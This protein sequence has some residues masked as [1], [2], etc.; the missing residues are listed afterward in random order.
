MK[1]YVLI[2]VALILSAFFLTFQN[3]HLMVPAALL[4][5]FVADRRAMRIF[6]RGKFLLFLAILAFGI[7]LFIGNRA[8]LFFGI[9]YSHDVFRMSLVMVSRSVVIL[10]SIKMFTNHISVEQMA[11]ALQRIRLNRFSEV[12]SISMRALPE[13]RIIAASTYREYR[14]TPKQKNLFSESFDWLVKLVV[15]LLTYADRF[16]AED[17]IKGE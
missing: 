11:A 8:D 14:R 15:R 16:S 6:L 17:S 12:F 7:P 1:R 4:A 10:L 5:V 3:L 9:P 2:S 13:I